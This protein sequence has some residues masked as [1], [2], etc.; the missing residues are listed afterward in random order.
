M[1]RRTNA[2]ILIDHL[3]GQ[4]S[5]QASPRR[6]AELTGWP[7]DKVKRVAE[8]ANADPDVELHIGKGGTVQTRGTERGSSNGLYDEVARVIT[9]FWGPRQLGLRNISV[10]DTSRAG[11]RGQGVWAHPDLVIAADPR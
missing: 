11:T 6:L 3:R 8:F 2:E 9:K 4:P 1:G 7:L 5:N 10:L